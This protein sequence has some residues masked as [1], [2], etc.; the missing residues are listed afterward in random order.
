MSLHQLL[1]GHLDGGALVG[2]LLW[3]LLMFGRDRGQFDLVRVVLIG[4]G[5]AGPFESREPVGQCA[6]IAWVCGDARRR[7]RSRA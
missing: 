1:G 7:A 2:S 6:I 3:S 4:R 5:F